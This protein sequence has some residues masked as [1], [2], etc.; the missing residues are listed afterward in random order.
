MILTV[1]L[2]LTDALAGGL[3]CGGGGGG[4]GGRR[5]KINLSSVMSSHTE[6]R[7]TV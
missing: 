5:V 1:L 6:Q 3:K 2:P 7:K 4:G